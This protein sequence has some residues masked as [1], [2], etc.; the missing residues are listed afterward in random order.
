MVPE[1]SR[2]SE[3]K[4]GVG[5]K[6]RYWRFRARDARGRIY[7]SLLLFIVV[8]CVLLLSVPSL[9]SR[10]TSRSQALYSA[11]WGTRRPVVANV[12]D[13]QTSYPE[14]Y[15]REAYA[16]PDAGQTIPENWMFQ[17]PSKSDTEENDRES[18]LIAPRTADA[19]AG[20]SAESEPEKAV[21]EEG[22]EPAGSDSGIRYTTG[23]AESDAYTLLLE[24]YPKVAALVSGS[25]SSLQFLSWG[26]REV[27]EG[28]YWVQLIFE[29][30]DN[31]EVY[32][33][34]VNLPS[35]EVQPLSYN[36]RMIS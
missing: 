5:L 33:W 4:K 6:E 21:V 12:S 36:A 15:K 27:E 24:K 35:S 14:D 1:G 3:T 10:L 28:I 34:E 26:G 29:T 20:V 7:G 22:S 2:P 31:R 30:G 8:V 18:A 16:F 32:I 23:K 25:D 11:I 13:E 9:R 17:V 19:D